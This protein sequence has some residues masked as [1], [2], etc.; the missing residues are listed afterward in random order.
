[1]LRRQFLRSGLIGGVALLTGVGMLLSKGIASAGPEEVDQMGISALIKALRSTGNAACLSAA[2]KLEA[3]RASN[4]DY[5]LHLRNAGLGA[6]DAEL[7]AGA[8]RQA[9]L[10]EGPALRS[11]SMSYNPGLTDAGVVALAQAFPP[12]LTELGLVECAIGDEGGAALLRWGKQAVGLQIIC[13]EGNRFSARI[14]KGFASLAQ[15]RKNLLV[16][17]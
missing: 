2:D 5:D 11:F 10:C 8:L 12:S 16:V 15:E 9:S 13:V 17:A 4:T 7:I 1:M 6:V 14:K 3:S